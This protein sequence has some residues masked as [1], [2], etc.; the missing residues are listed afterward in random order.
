MIVYVENP[1]EYKKILLE[2]TNEFFK[3]TGYKT[4]TQN[5]SHFCI[6]TV[7]MKNAS[8]KQ[9]LLKLFKT[10][11]YLDINLTKHVQTPYA[12][13]NKCWWKDQKRPTEVET[14]TIV[15]DLKNQ[16]SKDVNSPQIYQWFN[17][18][19]VK[20]PQIFVEIE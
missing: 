2:L 15:L 3:V 11:K 12:A 9:I 13:D 5:Q 6:L 7:N 18:I 8:W 19:L 17:A 1:S 4:N 14:H 20:F 16:H 10:M